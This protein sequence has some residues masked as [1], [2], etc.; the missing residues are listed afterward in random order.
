MFTDDVLNK[1]TPLNGW[2]SSIS[3]ATWVGEFL[4]MLSQLFTAS[5]AGTERMLSWFSVL[6]SKPRNRLGVEKAGKLVFLFQSMHQND[7]GS[8]LDGRAHCRSFKETVHGV[9]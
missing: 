7:R 2:K 9:L 6:H 1:V 5:S 4:Q 3:Q 8:G